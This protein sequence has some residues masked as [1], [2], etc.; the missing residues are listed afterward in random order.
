MLSEER[1]AEIKNLTVEQSVTKSIAE[2]VQADERLFMRLWEIYNITRVD[3]LEAQDVG[4][5]N[6]CIVNTVV[7]ILEGEEHTFTLPELRLILGESE[8]EKRYWQL[9]EK[10]NKAA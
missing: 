4:S 7:V 5:T 8:G 3:D 6:Y 10:L 2:V 1:I 9:L